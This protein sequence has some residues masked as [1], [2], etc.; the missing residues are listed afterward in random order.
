MPPF[1]KVVLL[2]TLT[3]PIEVILL[4]ISW[5][6]GKRGY[7]PSG[8]KRDSDFSPLGG[9]VTDCLKGVTFWAG[10]YGKIDIRGSAGIGRQA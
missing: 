4:S 7:L 9:G 6:A 5:G 2:P 3:R 8:G 10:G 1:L